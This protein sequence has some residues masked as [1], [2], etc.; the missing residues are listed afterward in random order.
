MSGPLQSTHAPITLTISVDA[1]VS[2]VRIIDH[3]RAALISRPIAAIIIDGQAP[4]GVTDRAALLI[5]SPRPG[6]TQVEAPNGTMRP[7]IVASDFTTHGKG[8]VAGQEYTLPTWAM[9]EF[10][11]RSVSGTVS[12]LLVIL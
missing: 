2:D 6:A 7:G 8:I 11:I 10:G 3:I 1:T 12:V 9:G 5:A 4:G